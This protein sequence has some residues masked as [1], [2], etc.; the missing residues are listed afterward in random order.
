L[1]AVGTPVPEGR[2]GFALCVEGEL[3]EVVVEELL[4]CCW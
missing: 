1:V 4:L 2:L 3:E